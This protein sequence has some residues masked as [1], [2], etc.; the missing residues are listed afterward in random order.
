MMKQPKFLKLAGF[1]ENYK[2]CDMSI[3]KKWI[4]ETY[5]VS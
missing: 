2:E 1:E 4:K 5:G 3:L